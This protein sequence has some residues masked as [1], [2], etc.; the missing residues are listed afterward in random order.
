M[1]GNKLD[2]GFLRVR[3]KLRSLYLERLCSRQADPLAGRERLIVTPFYDVEGGYARPGATS[4]EIECVGRL[5]DI[6][7][8]Y[9]I[10]S[11]YN[12]VARLA[13]DVP[14]LAEEIARTGAEVAS[15]SY[16]HS[17]LTTIGRTAVHENLRRTRALLEELG[18]TVRGHRCPQSAWDADVLDAL[19][20][21]GYAWSAEN[22]AEPHPY[23]IR[24]RGGRALWRF[25]VAGDDWQYESSGASPREMLDRWRSQVRQALGRRTHVALGFHP[26]IEAHPGRLTAVEEFF[27][28]LAEHDGVETMSFGDVL[29]LIEQ[30]KA[31]ELAAAHG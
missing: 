21:S 9:G 24:S 13:R 2:R 4:P 23:R 5:L 27:H 30:S 8:R 16:D 15:H 3:R 29:D 26:W 11:T 10:R 28:W 12:V 20:A 7:K 25:P 1:T 17:I 31:P 18:V 22:G 6:E 19:I 14:Q